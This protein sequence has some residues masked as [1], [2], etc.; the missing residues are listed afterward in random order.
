[1]PKY[2]SKT[3]QRRERYRIGR[4]QLIYKLGG[5]C[6]DCPEDDPLLLEFDHEIPRTWDA[7][8]TSRWVRLARYKREA[9]SGHV[10]LRCKTCN[11]KKGKP[12]DPSEEPI[13]E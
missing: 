2:E 8:K 7:A 11:R 3:I 6:A 1:M 12:H 5:K 13:P 10:V 4:L 9:E